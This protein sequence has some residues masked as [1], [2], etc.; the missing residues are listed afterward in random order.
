MTESPYTIVGRYGYRLASAEIQYLQQAVALMKSQGQKSVT[1]ES[2][3]ANPKD[4]FTAHLLES[5][6][7]GLTV[8]SALDSYR[9]VWSGGQS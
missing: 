8:E 2:L 3:A 7:K 4:H 5:C 9:P 6:R 1:W